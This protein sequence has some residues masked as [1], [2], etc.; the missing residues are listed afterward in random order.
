MICPYCS[1]AA[2]FEWRTTHTILIDSE[3]GLGNEIAYS[4][5]PNCSQIVIYIRKGEIV[6]TQMFESHIKNYSEQLIYPKK[7]NFQNCED[8]PKLYLE[9]YEEAIMVISSSPKASAA[10]SRRLLQTILREKYAI[11]ER[12]LS[13]EIEKFI[14]LSGVPSHLTEAVD[15]IRLIG[16][17]A[18]HPTKDINTG[19]I[20]P[21]E[22][23]EAEWLIEVIEALFDFTFIQPV[24]LERRKNELNLKL[25]KIGKPK[26]K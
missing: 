26:M 1:T 19:E 20:M 7:S 3:E 4:T 24:K 22:N 10:L 15:A 25:D 8:I 21:V 5:C 13:Q 11:K 2:K 6:N 23:G 18:A 9:D 14:Q 12:S 17:L 16:N